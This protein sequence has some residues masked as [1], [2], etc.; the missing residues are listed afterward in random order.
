MDGGH[1]RVSLLRHNRE[2]YEVLFV[3]SAT[4]A[5]RSGE[6]YV[7]VDRVA[8]NLEFQWLGRRKMQLRV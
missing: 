5:C 1:D 8:I 3:V 7:G 2:R 6:G 4:G